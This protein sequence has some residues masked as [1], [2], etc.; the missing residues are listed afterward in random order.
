[1]L[2][3]YLHQLGIRVDDRSFYGGAVAVRQIVDWTPR[4]ETV[5]AGRAANARTRG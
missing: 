1:L 2:I 3:E 4:Q 5:A